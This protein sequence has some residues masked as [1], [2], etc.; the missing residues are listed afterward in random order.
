M[1]GL[2]YLSPIVGVCIG[3]FISGKLGDKLVL[4]LARRNKG[5]W[6]S[7]QRMWLYLILVFVVPFSLILWG[8]GAAHG[9]HWFGLVFAM[10]V[11]GVSVSIG[12]QLALSYCIDTYKDLGADAVVSVMCIRNTMSFAIG[13]GVTPWVVNMGYQNAFLVA[14]FV[15]MAQVLTFLIFM[16]YGPALRAA[17]ADRYRREVERAEKSGYSH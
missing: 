1:V 15:G 5:I 4:R 2:T 7:E 10:C 12:A 8:V 13:Y 3:S 16:K 9:V 6:E 11:T 14:A 17:S